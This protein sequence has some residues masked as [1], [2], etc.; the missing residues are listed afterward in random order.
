METGS[1][2]SD[3]AIGI[4]MA[5]GVLAVLGALFM[6]GGSTQRMQAWAFAAAMVAAS[7]CVV[8]IHLYE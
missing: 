7:L 2:D 6:V 3:K 8:V 1:V 4:S 5:F